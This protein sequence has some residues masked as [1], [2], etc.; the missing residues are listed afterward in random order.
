MN[1]VEDEDNVIVPHSLNVDN[2]MGYFS[3]TVD[4]HARFLYFYL[5]TNMDEENEIQSFPYLQH[6][7]GFTE[8]QLNKSIQDLVD[9]GKMIRIIKYCKKRLVP[10][11]REYFKLS[12]FDCEEK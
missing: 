5:L 3:P 9:S 11:E 2:W 6:I 8:E 7:L 12:F 4:V 10:L 1:E